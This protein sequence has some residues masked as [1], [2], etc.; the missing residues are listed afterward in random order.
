[1]SPIDAFRKVIAESFPKED[2]AE[3]SAQSRDIIAYIDKFPEARLD[4]IRSEKS[5]EM[6]AMSKQFMAFFVDNI[7]AE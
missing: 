3:K 1:M 4:S 7:N 2:N 6:L 5:T